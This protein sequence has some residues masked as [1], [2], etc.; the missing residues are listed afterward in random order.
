MSDL[1]VQVKIRNAEKWHSVSFNS[2]VLTTGYDHSEKS[3][4]NFQYNSPHNCISTSQNRKKKSTIVER[5]T[6]SFLYWPQWDNHQ[7]LVSLSYAQQQL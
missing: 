5:P 6:L 3:T 1:G 2:D 4:C 7:L